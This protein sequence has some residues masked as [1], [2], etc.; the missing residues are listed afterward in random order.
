MGTGRAG[1]RAARA[2]HDSGTARVA[3][4]HGT[5]AH[6]WAVGRAVNKFL[7]FGTGTARGTAGGTVA[8]TWAG[9][10]ARHGTARA[11]PLEN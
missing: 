3:A 11:L 10:P 5:V 7:E 4:R 6:L 8:G 9:T 1:T 2:R